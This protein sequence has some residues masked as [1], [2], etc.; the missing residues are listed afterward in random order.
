MQNYDWNDFRCHEI[1]KC[2]GLIN[3]VLLDQLTPLVQLKQYLAQMTI[4]KPTHG[5]SSKKTTFLL[6]E[7]PEL[8]N[9]YLKEIEDYGQEKLIQL[10]TKAFFDKSVTAPMAKKLS[11]AYN[12]EKILELQGDEKPSQTVKNKCG[13]C[14][15]AA[16]KKCSSCELVFYCSRD[17]QA[18]HWPVHK[19]F[20]KTNARR[21]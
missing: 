4:Q 11:E 15:Q 1:S 9:E 19:S 6:E 10:Q 18:Q 14:S 5:G 8:Q 3:E 16:E 17:C 2:L 7:I 13:K 21:L 20:C 12:I